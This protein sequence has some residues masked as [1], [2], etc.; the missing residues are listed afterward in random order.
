MESLVAATEI[1]AASPKEQVAWCEERNMP[2][3]EIIQGFTDIVPMFFARTEEAGLLQP[4][5]KEALQRISRHFDEMWGENV[6]AK[7]D[8]LWTEAG[9]ERPEWAEVRRLAQEALRLMRV[10]GP[11]DSSGL[12]Y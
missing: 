6:Q 12:A 11:S 7:D 5:D 1:V 10:H 3:D 4:E 9:L 2:V 8:D